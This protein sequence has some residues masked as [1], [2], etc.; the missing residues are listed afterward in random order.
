MRYLI[1]IVISAVLIIC[2]LVY[3]GVYLPVNHSE[4]MVRFLVKKGDTARDV[5]ENLKDNGLIRY[6]IAFRAYASLIDKADK[7]VIGEYELS[8]SMNIPEIVNKLSSGDRIKRMI[9]IIEGWDLKD[10]K[11]YLEEQGIK[12]EIDSSL[13]GY[14]FPD[15]YELSPEDK[16]D[17]VVKMMTD[18][19][20]DKVGEISSDDIIMASLLEKEV[21]TLEDKKIVSGILWKRLEADMPL[22]VDATITYLT[23]KSKVS[24][25]DLEIDSH[26]NT[27][28][29]KGLPV[30]PI[31]NP[32]LE[33]IE[34]AENPIESDYWFYLSTSEGETIFSKNFKE[35]Q[36][37]IEK[38]LK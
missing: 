6:E 38:Y 24:L 19:F 16:I 34:A 32:G 18:N 22:Q 26:Y 5:A 10:I 25:D 28:K 36:Q 4:E 11:E 9:T 15:T 8:S 7:L 21:I 17:D 30:G 2:F 14:L 31:C 37:A 1:T 29:Y 12:G 13:E 23:G 33:S 35:H 20:N 3:Q 27:Y